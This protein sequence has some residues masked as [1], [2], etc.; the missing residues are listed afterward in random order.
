[1]NWVDIIIISILIYTV[2][3]GLSFGLVLSV[4]NIVQII[5]SAIL[6]K[7][8][9]IYVYGYINDNPK[10][11]NLFNKMVQFIL[12]ILFYSKSKKDLD[13]IPNLISKGLVNIII[14]IFSII[15]IFWLSNILISILLELF[16]FLL[17][18]PILKQ[19]NK[20]GGII[21]GLL[22]GLFII[23]LLS[24]I[25]TPI[26]SVF[27]KTFLGKGILGSRILKYIKEISLFKGGYL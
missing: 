9:Y 20:I 7:K 14:G 8:Y 11:Y 16:S 10:I 27:P 6:T 22:E 19:L 23:Y 21:F 12:N 2:I 24:L 17:K 13:F 4:F 26:S 5:L 15:I 18:V 3:K 25:L 1:M